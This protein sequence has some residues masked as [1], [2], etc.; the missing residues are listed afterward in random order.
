MDTQLKRMLIKIHI[1]NA[2]FGLG[3][4]LV[5]WLLNFSIFSKESV[6]SKFVYLLIN[7]NYH[8]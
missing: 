3:L 2:W 7:A 8:K 1:Q 4:C 6:F 5:N